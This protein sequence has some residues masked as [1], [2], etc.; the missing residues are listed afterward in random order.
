MFAEMKGDA[1]VKYFPESTGNKNRACSFTLTL[2]S[3]N[4]S[5][6]HIV[7]ELKIALQHPKQ[8]FA[9]IKLCFFFQSGLNKRQRFNS[10][11]CVVE[12]LLSERCD[13][14]CVSC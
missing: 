4:F 14:A 11:A 2:I 10:G 3:G 13:S 7:G 8:P 5:A 12:L 6:L 9:A 1:K